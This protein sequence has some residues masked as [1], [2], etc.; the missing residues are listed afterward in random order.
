MK[1]ECTPSPSDTTTKTP[2]PDSTLLMEMHQRV[3]KDDKFDVGAFL[4]KQRDSCASDVKE[5]ITGL[6]GFMDKDKT[7]KAVMETNCKEKVDVASGKRSREEAYETLA[8]KRKWLQEKL[9][10][11]LMVRKKF[12]KEFWS[13]FQPALGGAAVQWGYKGA[14]LLTMDDINND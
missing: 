1:G 11:G 2:R 8:P 7:V 5:V 4:R 3:P 14:E 12:S 13:P 9:A 10:E 6:I